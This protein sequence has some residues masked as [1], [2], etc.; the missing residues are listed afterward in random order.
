M[1]WCWCWEPIELIFFN[2]F[3]SNLSKIPVV[4]NS[5]LHI[6][7]LFMFFS[8]AVL[9]GHLPTWRRLGCVEAGQTDPPN[10]W[11]CERL[12]PVT[13]WSYTVNGDEV[14]GPYKW[15]KVYKLITGV[16]FHLT[17]RGYKPHMANWWRVIDGLPQMCP[18]CDYLW[19]PRQ[20]SK[21]INCFAKGVIVFCKR[22]MYIYFYMD[23]MCKIN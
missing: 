20:G 19:R 4:S 15:P 12:G 17:S 22:T 14:W 9:A 3:T 10:C 8:F 7:L 18:W 5:C 6:L 21:E 23:I 11:G 2:Q 13:S 1:T 16:I